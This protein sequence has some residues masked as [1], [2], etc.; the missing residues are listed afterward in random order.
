MNY[1]E[2]TQVR[3]EQVKDWLREAEHDRL[4]RQA[5][6][7]RSARVR[8]SINAFG[9]SGISF[10]A[11]GLLLVVA[12]LVHLPH[13][14]ITVTPSSPG[15]RLI[16]LSLL[17]A[18]LLVLWGLVG[19]HI[20]QRERA[21]RVGL[22]G[23]ALTLFGTVLLAG[24]ILTEAFV[25]PFIGMSGEL[26]DSVGPLLRAFIFTPA[27]MVAGAGVYLGYLLVGL[28]RQRAGRLPFHAGLVLSVGAQAAIFIS[29]LA[30]TS[31]TAGIGL[32]A[33]GLGYMVLGSVLLAG[34]G[35]A[36]LHAQ[37]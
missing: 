6:R 26:P 35:R 32:V 28:A 1:Y 17:A 33:F 22:V 21:G 25:L 36:A 9:W 31:A 5:L 2:M 23:F 29:L 37:A 7:C 10:L 24:S 34:R 14:P 13:T 15:E 12:S 18:L 20:R 4:V 27:V 19:L 3:N 11:A 8:F 16:H 30:P